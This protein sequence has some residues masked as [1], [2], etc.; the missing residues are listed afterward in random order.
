M[1][2]MCSRFIYV[3]GY[4]IV[5]CWLYQ[6]FCPNN[7]RDTR[8]FLEY[9]LYVVPYLR[10]KYESC[11]ALPC[12]WSMLWKNA[13]DLTFN[14]YARDLYNYLCM[15]CCQVTQFLLS[16]RNQPWKVK[17]LKIMLAEWKQLI[18]HKTKNYPHTV[19]IHYSL[20]IVEL[21]II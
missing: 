4:N 2:M 9:L 1:Y 8:F 11:F 19:T 21:W 5:F 18:K 3:Y 7:I 13:G 17:M 16:F 10:I 20:F 6:R 15:K 12:S 14:L